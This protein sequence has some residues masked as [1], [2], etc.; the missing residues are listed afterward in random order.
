M[1]VNWTDEQ[2]SAIETKGGNILVAAAAGSGKTAVLVERLIRKITDKENPVSID[3]FLLLTF[4]EAA[5]SEMRRKISDAIDKK[6]SENPDDEYLKEQSIKVGSAAIST[7]HAFCSRILSNNAHLTN[8][9]V[10]F[11][12]IDATENEVLKAQALNDI[13]ESYYANIDKK[14][15]FRELVTGW[16]GIKGDDYLR[17]TILKIHNFS[18]SLAYPKKW[19]K[20]AY[21]DTYKVLKNGGGIEETVWAE[22][23]KK[24][25]YCLC[26]EIDGGV[27]IMADIATCKMPPDHPCHNYFV[28]MKEDFSSRFKDIYEDSENAA[29][30]LIELIHTF[31]IPRM[32]SKKGVEDVIDQAIAIRDDVVKTALKSA[33]GLLEIFSDENISRTIKCAQPVRVLISIVH[34]TEKLHQRLKNERGV[35]DFND[36]EHGLFHLLV[37]ERGEE[38]PLCKKLRN[39]YYEILVDEFQDT[40]ALQFEIFK[41]L[42]KEQGNLFMVGDIKQSIY[43]FRNA[44]PSIFMRLYKSYGK[45]DGGRLIKLFKNFRSRSEIIDAANHIFRAV[46]SERV[47][48]IDYT[49]DEYLINGA[50]YP[51]SFDKNTEILITAL[52]HIDYEPIDEMSRNELEAKAVADR[53]AKL[54]Y[55]EKIQVTDKE[56]GQLREATLSDIA[57]L[58]RNK[59]EGDEIEMALSALGIPSVSESGFKYLNSIEVKTVLCFL[60]IIDNPLQDI[61]LIAVMRSPIFGFTLEELAKIRTLKKGR[62]YDAVKAAEDAKTQSFVNDLEYLR[63]CSKYMGVD[64]LVFKICNEYHYI[65]IVSGMPDGEVKKANL[66]LLQERASDYEKGVLSGLFNFMKYIEMLEEKDKDLSGARIASG[67]AVSVMTIHKSK[68]LEFPIVILAGTI[69]KFNFR[70]TQQTIMWDDSLGIAVDYI[71]TRQRVRFNLPSKKLMARKKAEELKAEEMRLLYVAITRAKEK[72]IISAV[73]QS[74]DNKW[75]SAYFDKL[76]R[77]YPSLADGMSSMRDWILSAVLSHPD[78]GLLRELAERHDIIPNPNAMGKFEVKMAENFTNFKKQDEEKREE[79]SIKMPIDRLEFT[80]PYAD[81][82]RLPIKLS[83]SELKRRRMSEGE[84][85]GRLI[86]PVSDFAEDMSEITGAERGTI[87]HFVMQHIDIAKTNSKAEIEKQIEKMTENNVIT[88][89]QAEAVDVDAVF[90]FFE[91]ILGIRLKSA[92]HFEREFD[93]YMLVKPDEVESGMEIGEDVILQGIADCFFYE[94]DGIVLIDYKTDRVNEYTAK[95]RSKRYALQIEYY[96]KGLEKILKKRVKEKYLYFLNCDTAIKM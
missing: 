44:D 40:N 76:Y 69:K 20:S 58:T 22:F 77:L 36:L 62:F 53:I 57:V 88:K 32:P 68:G 54:I 41:R 39:Y 75:K 91:S 78:A 38:T 3:K 10:G 35:I 52:E 14:Q 94:D 45:G 61:P 96:A 33:K 92:E 7:I 25:L 89:A 84:A 87:T 24:E 9:P 50:K 28:G 2:L 60:Q 72:L 64:E 13:L 70:D 56:T 93:F 95:E 12:L 83:V 6:L 15:G 47:G 46:M 51:D 55:D 48:G 5:A 79:N 4:T 66:K 74:R 16:G 81:L 73:V 21:K 34:Q 23:L 42:S 80:Y 30:K 82:S 90:K 19:L 65:S 37:N 11:S 59:A 17:E 27:K 29:D 43:K 26:T 85:V 49:K 8:L 86:E 18:R 31:D 1:A 71:D 63:R 67:D